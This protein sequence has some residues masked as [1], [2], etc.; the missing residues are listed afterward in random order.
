MGRLRRKVK[1]WYG[2]VGPVLLSLLTLLIAA[3]ATGGSGG[4]RGY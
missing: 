4:G 3:C 2:R 1:P